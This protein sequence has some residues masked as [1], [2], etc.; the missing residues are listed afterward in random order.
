MTNDQNNKRIAKNTLLLY[1]RLIFTMLVALYTSRVVLNVLGESDFGVYNVVGG[2]VAMFSMFSG[3]FSSAITR[4]LTYEMGKKN[5]SKLKHIFSTSITIQ[6]VLG[7]LIFIA[8]EIAGQWFIFNKMTIAPDRVHAAIIVLHCSLLNFV[9]NLL[10]VPYNASI[11]AHEDMKAFAYISIAEVTLKL[12]AV[13]LLIVILHDK[14]IV[15]ACLLLIVSIIIRLTY[16]FYCRRYEECRFHLMIDKPL[17]KE[18]GIFVMWNSVGVAAA[19][20]RSEGVNILINVFFTPAVNAARGISFQVN[21]AVTQFSL[22]FMKA[23][24]PQITKSYASNNNEYMLSL[25]FRGAKLSFFL[26]MILTAALLVRTD[27]VMMLWLNIVPAHTV[28]F[29]R[30]MLLFTLVESISMPL[31]TVMMATGK[32]RNYQII[33]GGILLLIL[34]VSWILLRLGFPPESTMVVYIVFSFAS[35]CARL[36]MLRKMIQFPPKA[37]LQKVFL[38]CVIAFVLTMGSVRLLSAMLPNSFVGFVSLL[39]LSFVI[40]ALIIYVVGLENNERVFI[41]KKTSDLI[42]STFNKQK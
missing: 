27:Y 26:L 12:A 1:F 8:G 30:L 5:F 18:M 35:L 3:S 31:I 32:I 4:F 10:S 34:P 23:I 7:I 33:V 9:V 6:V 20:L 39:M 42:H 24:N 14:L 37:F 11:I 16:S 28:S 19:A 25:V 21:N 17:F 22:N 15:Y 40:S 29:V 36:I 41:N 2:V 13:Y 38:R